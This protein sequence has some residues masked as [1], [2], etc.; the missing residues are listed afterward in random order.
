MEFGNTIG[1]GREKPSGVR[2]GREEW[3]FSELGEC[4]IT[5]F[6][7]QANEGENTPPR[8]RLRGNARI[9]ISVQ[10]SENGGYPISRGDKGPGAHGPARK[11]P[12]APTGEIRHYRRHGE[13]ESGSGSRPHVIYRIGPTEGV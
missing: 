4:A 5:T 10:P 12:S 7:K 9:A 1:A 2:Q 3:D 13:Y 8:L 6:E 11:D